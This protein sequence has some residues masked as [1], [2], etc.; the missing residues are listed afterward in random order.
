LALAGQLWAGGFYLSV[1][2]PGASPEARKVGAALTIKA[3]GCHDPANAKVTAQAI[4]MVNGELRTIP[5]KVTAMSEPGVFALARQWPSEGRWVIQ[6]LGHN[7]G[8]VTSSL[9]RAGPAGVD[10]KSWRGEMREFTAAEIE[11]MLRN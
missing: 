7:D 10:L 11:D 8:V 5:L 4:G 2:N 3:V 6:L 1:E 9:L